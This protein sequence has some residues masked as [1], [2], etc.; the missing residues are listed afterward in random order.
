MKRRMVVGISGISGISGTTGTSYGT[1][2]RGRVTWRR[3]EYRFCKAGWEHQ[4]RSRVVFN[5]GE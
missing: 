5:E 4:A 3:T 1:R 2:A